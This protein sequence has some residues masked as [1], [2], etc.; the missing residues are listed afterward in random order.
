MSRQRSLK[1]LVLSS[2]SP[3]KAT[4]LRI[5]EE[6]AKKSSILARYRY[7]AGEIERK[8]SFAVKWGFTLFHSIVAASGGS[9]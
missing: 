3:L 4:F 5:S 1:N 6:A 8:E 7:L 9:R 2:P